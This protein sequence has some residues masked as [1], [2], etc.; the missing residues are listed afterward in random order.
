M[1][2][3][4]LAV[5]E[6]T[7][8]TAGTLEERGLISFIRP[9]S[10]DDRISVKEDFMKGENFQTNAH[11]FHSV[12]ITYTEIF[13]SSHPDGE[14]EIVFL[15]DSAND[16]KPLYFV[17]ALDKRERYV[18]KL[19]AG[20]VGANDYIAVKFPVNDPEFSSF[21]VWH[22]TVHCELTD[23]VNPAALAPSF[24][25]LEPENLTVN[26]TIEKQYGISLVLDALTE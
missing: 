7:K 19:A 10:V 5:R 14:D 21:I 22:G 8:E 12:T 3:I 16:V 23:S 13:L 25:V 26:Y 9:P 2:N 24:F 4:K 18:E 20:V 17:F 11:G 6:C 15:W 1:K